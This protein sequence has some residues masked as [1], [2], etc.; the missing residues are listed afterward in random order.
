M[1]F[2]RGRVLYK[3]NLSILQHE[4]IQELS[5]LKTLKLRLQSL[6]ESFNNCKNCFKQKRL[7]KKNIYHNFFSE[8][9][10]NVHQTHIDPFYL[11]RVRLLHNFLNS[12]QPTTHIYRN[13]SFAN[14]AGEGQNYGTLLVKLLDLGSTSL[15]LI[16]R[17]STK[18]T[19]LLFGY[20]LQI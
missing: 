8:I 12:H 19:N 14:Q 9:S 3:I 10:E 15:V 11:K 13:L 1:I 5:E 2:N 16:L 4:R 7:L 20:I 18:T 6:S 17:T